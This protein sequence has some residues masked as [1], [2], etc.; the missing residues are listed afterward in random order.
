MFYYSRNIGDYHRDAGFLTTLQ[1]GIYT[2]LMD[3]CYGHEKPVPDATAH[4]IARV[5]R[6]EVEPIL[7]LFFTRDGDVWRHKRIDEEIATYHARGDQ[8]RENGKKGGRPPGSGKKKTQPKPG[9][10]PAGTKPVSKAKKKAT[11][12]LGENINVPPGLQRFLDAYPK[13]KRNKLAEV[14]KVWERDGLEDFADV[15]VKDV[16]R[17]K[18][19]HW[20]WIKDGGQ[21]IPG[22]QVYLNGK[23]WNDDI[24]AIPAAAG[25]RRTAVEQQNADVATDWASKL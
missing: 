12:G 14:V 25:G 13:G 4:M 18:V 9:D 15:I 10:N 11:A 22:S 8:S 6:E 1:H 19:E 7:S 21:F 17:R 5:D 3:W 20:Q 23:R 2:L 24:E 16:E